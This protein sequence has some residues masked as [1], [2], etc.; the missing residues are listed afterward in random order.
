MPESFRSPCP[1]ASSL[2]I[3]GNRWTVPEWFAKARPEDFHPA[4]SATARNST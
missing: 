1:I 2:D 3:L 4:V